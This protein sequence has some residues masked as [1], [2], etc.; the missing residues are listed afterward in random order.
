LFSLLVLHT[1]GQ[2]GQHVRHFEFMLR[3]TVHTVVLLTLFSL[4][5][6]HTSGQPGQHVRHFEFMRRYGVHSA[7]DPKYFVLNHVVYLPT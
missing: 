1:S 6:L 7:A 4:L 3:Y 5:V 2:P